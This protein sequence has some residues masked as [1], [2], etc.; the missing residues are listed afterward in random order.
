MLDGNKFSNL[1][2]NILTFRWHERWSV[3]AVGVTGQRCSWSDASWPIRNKCNLASWPHF[4]E[5]HSF[6]SFV[7]CYF[8]S[9]NILCKLNFYTFY[10]IYFSLHL[11]FASTLCLSPTA[12][13]QIL[14]SSFSVASHTSHLS[15]LWSPGILTFNLLGIPLVGADI[16]GFMEET[17]EELCVRWTQLGAFYPFARNHNSINMKVRWGLR[18]CSNC[19]PSSC[20]PQDCRIE[21]HPS[22]AVLCMFFSHTKGRS[23]VAVKDPASRIWP[24]LPFLFSSKLFKLLINT[25][26]KLY[27]CSTIK[28]VWFFPPIEQFLYI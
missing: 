10:I 5:H 26:I 21:S 22:H 6:Q 8:H 3:F 17:Q 27:T 9:R 15:P 18:R 12:F 19:F 14:F 7:C 23:S 2:F 13:F 11:C 28:V 25:L 24:D 4:L 20:S 1:N 16:C